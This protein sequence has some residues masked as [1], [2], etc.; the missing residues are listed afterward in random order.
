MILK[1]ILAVMLQVLP[2]CV[3]GFESQACPEPT[4]KT[5]ET[6]LAHLVG[7]SVLYPM[8]TTGFERA[9]SCLLGFHA[10]KDVAISGITWDTTHALLRIM[11]VDPAQFFR[12]LAR[13]KAVAVE[14]WIQSFEHAAGWPRE[15]CP[16]P[17]PMTIARRSIEAVR[18]PNEAEELLRKR[19][20]GAL[21]RWPCRVAI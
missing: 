19:V 1:I 15:A 12:V 11:S 13:D 10:R 3:L 16:K 2:F 6:E 9:V 14:H 8:D 5:V 20:L 21:K 17:D 7:E 18:L 4:S